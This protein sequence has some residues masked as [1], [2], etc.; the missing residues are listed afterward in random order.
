M[1]KITS[2]LLIISS[3]F[4]LSSLSFSYCGAEEVTKAAKVESITLNVENIKKEDQEKRNEKIKKFLA[5]KGK[6]FPENK[7]MKIN[8]LLH[9][10]KEDELEIVLNVDFK[11]PGYVTLAAIFGGLGGLDNFAL[12]GHFKGLMN[13]MFN[14]L[15]TFSALCQYKGYLNISKDWS[16]M[17]DIVEIFYTLFARIGLVTVPT[18]ILNWV[19]KMSDAGARTRNFNYQLLL[20]TIGVK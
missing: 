16:N 14:C 15:A 12:R 11:K 18:A 8:S 19:S 17:D 10:L 9:S 13:F 2:I 5:E 7:L 20:N 6:C 3:L 1:K 4:T